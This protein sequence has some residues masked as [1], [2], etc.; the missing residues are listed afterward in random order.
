MIQRGMT[1]KEYMEKRQKI[2]SDIKPKGQ[3]GG[4]EHTRMREF[5]KALM[6][7][8]YEDIPAN[9]YNDFLES[10]GY[11]DEDYVKM[12]AQVRRSSQA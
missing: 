2:E 7:Y 3:D 8:F 9:K 4:K 5:M 10:Y 1:Y 12:L 6:E 11:T